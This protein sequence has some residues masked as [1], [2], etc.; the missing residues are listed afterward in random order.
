M[1]FRKQGMDGEMPNDTSNSGEPLRR[2]IYCGE[3]HPGRGMY[4]HVRWSS[5]DGHG[6][7]GDVPSDFEVS[8]CEKVGTVDIGINSRTDYQKDHDRY[9][10][11]YCGETC[12]GKSGLGVH[13][14]R[15]AD[16]TLHPSR[17]EERN[18]ADHTRFPAT[19]DG[20]I[21]VPRERYT[22]IIRLT[23]KEKSEGYQ[24]RVEPDVVPV[25]E[26][27]ETGEDLSREEVLEEIRKDFKEIMKRGDDVSPVDAFRIVKSNFQPAAT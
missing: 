14:S 21:L 5:G 8:D 4:N 13:L 10:C 24:V 20:E 27:I 3:Y 6:D 16:D 2:C 11:N 15:K 18:Y 25:S 9:I 1:V 12:I 7:R 19:E 22:E 17:E 23:D 26:A